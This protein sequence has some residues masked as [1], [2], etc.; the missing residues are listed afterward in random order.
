MPLYWEIFPRNDKGLKW[1][2]FPIFS[3]FCFHDTKCPDV[4]LRLATVAASVSMDF[5]CTSKK[6]KHLFFF[7]NWLL[8]R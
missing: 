3:D 8:R 4:F 6:D 7:E 2:V 5:M 1:V